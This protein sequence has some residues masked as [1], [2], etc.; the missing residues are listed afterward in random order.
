MFT[1]DVI[2]FTYD[3]SF[4][5]NA[6]YPDLWALKTGKMLALPTQMFETKC[7]NISQSLMRMWK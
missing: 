5:Q 2:M 7:F 6:G 3:N 4:G 1:L